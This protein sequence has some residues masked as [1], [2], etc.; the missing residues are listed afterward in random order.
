MPDEIANKL[1]RARGVAGWHEHYALHLPRAPFVHAC[2]EKLIIIFQSRLAVVRGNLK[3]RHRSREVLGYPEA[4]SQNR[5]V[6]ALDGKRARAAAIG[7]VSHAGRA[8]KRGPRIHV[9]R[10][11]NVE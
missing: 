8:L 4:E 9:A 2:F 10:V 5:I 6:V 11:V 7:L 3:R 1:S